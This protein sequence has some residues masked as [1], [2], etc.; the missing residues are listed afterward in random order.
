M[1]VE[2]YAYQIKCLTLVPVGCFPKVRHRVDMRVFL[3]KQH[4]QT[5]SLV[6]SC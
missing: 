1:A 4:L 3:R 5:E 2:Y 6:M